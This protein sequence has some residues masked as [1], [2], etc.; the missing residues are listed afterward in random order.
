MRL[1]YPPS[2][3]LLPPFTSV[4]FESCPA[5][6]PLAVILLLRLYA[7]YFL[8]RRVLV[9]MAC[10]SVLAFAA[11]AGVMGSVLAQITGA[12]SSSSSSLTHNTD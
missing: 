6:T 8:N 5:L 4:T 12:L 11:S 7:L 9:F 3:L 10:T 1:P 2:T